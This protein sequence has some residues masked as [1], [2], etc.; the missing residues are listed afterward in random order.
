[1]YLSYV[2]DILLECVYVYCV[3]TWYLWRQKK[4]SNALDMECWT[5]M[6]HHVSGKHLS[7][8]INDVCDQITW[9]RQTHIDVW[10]AL[11]T[12]RSDKDEG[13]KPCFACM[14]VP[15]LYLYQVH[16]LLCG[17]SCGIPVLTLGPR[18]SISVWTEDQKL[19][20]NHLGLQHLGH[21][22]PF[23]F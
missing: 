10:G 23:L 17:Y 9:N 11:S 1:M 15:F 21:F 6:S 8:P 22:S 13:E 19:S 20:R 5:V 18:F 14:L 7:S 16:L 2:Y 4:L 3:H 12:C